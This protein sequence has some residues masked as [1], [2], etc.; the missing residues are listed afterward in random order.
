MLETELTNQ[1]PLQLTNIAWYTIILVV[2]YQGQF[3]TECYKTKV[4]KAINTSNITFD[5]HL[6]TALI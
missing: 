6:K 5:T 4:A 3:S 2:H 1:P